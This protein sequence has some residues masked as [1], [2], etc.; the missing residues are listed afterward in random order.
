VKDL[1]GGRPEG[2]GKRNEENRKTV[3]HE[4][5]IEE[6]D[7]YYVAVEEEYEKGDE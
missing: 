2:K 6:S 1:P 3:S 5:F 4:N 7:L